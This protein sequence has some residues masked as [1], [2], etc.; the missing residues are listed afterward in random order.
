MHF[1]AVRSYVPK[2]NGLSLLNK[3]LK[4]GKYEISIF[5]AASYL[6]RQVALSLRL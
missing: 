3:V 2:G 5:T 4:S 1:W 6:F